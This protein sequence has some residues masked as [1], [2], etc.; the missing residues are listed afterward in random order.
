MKT[1]A[2]TRDE[3]AGSV[4]AVPP[5]CRGVDGRINRGE[6]GKLIRHL[7]GGGVRHL[8]YGGNANVYHMPLSEY[9]EFLD[10]VAGEAGDETAVVPAVGPAWGMMM[11]QAKELKGRGF[12]SVMVLPHQGI[13]SDEGVAT[14]I[15]RFAEALGEPVVV[16]LK[17]EGYLDVAGVKG[18]VEDG[19]VSWIKYAVVRDD[20]RVDG[21][22]SE[23]VE[24]IDPGMMIS[25]IGEQPAIVHMRDFGCL[26]YTSGCVCVAPGLSTAMLRAV[27]A[28]DFEEA[29]RIR[30]VFEGLEDLRNDINPIRVLHDAVGLAGVAETGPLMPLL[31]N[32]GE[33][34]LGRVKEAAVALLGVEAGVG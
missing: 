16:Y 29:E 21:Y 6:N 1:G 12:A 32:L 11:D 19:V 17:Y 7:E 28:G 25:G 34:D 4:V 26:G 10:V 30:G 24:V 22:L 2:L 27:R 14:G 3:L 8:L 9:A 31:S 18:L 20:P 13:T 23:L 5:L 15:R 33:R